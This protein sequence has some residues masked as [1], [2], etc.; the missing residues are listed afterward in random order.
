MLMHQGMLS[1][2]LFFFF[3]FP[4]F[5]NQLRCVEKWSLDGLVKHLF[6]KRLFKEKDVRCGQWDDFVL[7][8]EQKRY[9]ATD[10]YVSVTHCTCLHFL[11]IF[12]KSVHSLVTS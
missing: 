5:K 3:L 2:F 8:E 12:S 6:S 4:F 11:Q 9:A 7:T 10:A 1:V